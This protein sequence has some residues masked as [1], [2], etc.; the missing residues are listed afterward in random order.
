MDTTISTPNINFPE[1][2]KLLTALRIDLL[3]I[4]RR[5]GK[6]YG[7]KNLPALDAPSLVPYYGNIKT[8]AE[9]GRSDVLTIT[10]PDMHI[11]A[12]QVLDA[13]T[14][15]KTT[16]ITA[17][18]DRLKHE[19]DVDML[20]L[21]GKTPPPKKQGKNYLAVILA[22]AVNIADLIFNA[23][24][25]E[26]LG[27]GLLVSVGIGLGVSA[28]MYVL[29]NAI[30]YF[31]RRAQS[32]GKKFYLAAAGC[33][34]AACGA[35]WVFSDFRAKMMSE[36]DVSISPQLFF[37]LNIFFFVAS[38]V[39]PII[40]FK[41]RKESDNE[42]ELARRFASVEER[43]EE[44]KRKKTELDAL[45]KAAKEER[46]KHLAI[47]SY[48]AHTMNRIT[49]MY[50]EAVASFKSQILLTR[51]DRSVPGCFSEP[52]ADLS[53]VDFKLPPSLHLPA[54]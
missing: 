42:Q 27:H 50:Y 28:A 43:K 5:D 17:D 29:S 38:I 30:V 26:F 4:A 19:N 46:E 54:A 44:I 41:P 7:L 9:H 8:R 22:A 14:K 6:Y 2:E 23:M 36:S 34:L 51:Q 24:A 31:L 1:A 18:I 13:N 53:G 48:V 16:E 47:L 15:A 33:F 40:F 32:E 35:F 25:F 49:T 21:E 11:S 20:Q 12:I 3:E 45:N 10:Q 39:I 52:I 37:L